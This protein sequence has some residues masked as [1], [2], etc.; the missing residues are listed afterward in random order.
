LIWAALHGTEE[1]VEL[2]C[3]MGADPETQDKGDN[4][5]LMHAEKKG[6]LNIFK[7]LKDCSKNRTGH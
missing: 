5:A 4:T 6:R 3:N 2:L 7:L 1:V